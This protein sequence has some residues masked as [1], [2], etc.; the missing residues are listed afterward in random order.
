MMITLLILTF[1]KA[2]FNKESGIEGSGLKRIDW[3]KVKSRTLFLIKKYA[4][5]AGR[6]ATKPLLTLWYVLEDQH[7]STRDKAVIAGAIFYIVLPVDLI[8]SRIYKLFGLMDEGT[9]IVV[10]TKKVMQNITPE[11][12]EKVARTLDDWFGCE[13]EIVTAPSES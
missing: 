3:D 8:P 13:V 6:V 5:K 10:A 7:T 2:I 4:V 12:K 9:A 11:I 1:F